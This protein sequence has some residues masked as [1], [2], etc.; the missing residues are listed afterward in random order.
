MKILFSLLFFVTF[1]TAFAQSYWEQNISPSYSQLMDTLKAWSQ[2]NPELELYQMGESDANVPIYICVVNGEKDSTKTFEK[3]R[4]K[5]TIL[6][7]NAIHPGEPDGINAMLIWIENWMKSEKKTNDLPV[8]AFI[9]AYNVDGMLNRNSSS[10]AN[11]N[12]PDEYGFRGTV[13]NYDLNRDFVKMDAQNS[14]VF[15]KIFHALDPDIFIDNHV[16]NGADYQY[17]LTYITSLKERMSPYL[18]ELTFSKMIP[19]MTKN[20]ARR[21]WELFPYVDLI[22]ETPEEGITAFNDLARYSNGYSSLFHT[23]S[24]TVETHMLKPFPQ[25]VKGTQAFMEETIKWVYLNQKQIEEARKKSFEWQENQAYFKFNYKRTKK[26]ES[27][28]F[29]GFKAS[30]PTSEVTG[31]PRL[32]Y[33][34]LQPY[35]KNIPYFK[36]HQASDSVLVPDY[37][38][39][40]S[41]EKEVITRLKANKINY[42][43]VQQDSTIN[44]TTTK[45]ESFKAINQPYEGHFKLEEIKITN[46]QESVTLHKGDLIIP[47]HQRGM[48]FLLQL[49]TPQAEDSYLSW[50]FFDSYLQQKEHFSSYIFVDEAEQILNSNPVLKKEFEEKKKND[51]QFRK[52]EWEQLNFIYMRSKF[53]EQSYRKLPVYQIFH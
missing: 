35:Q 42:K 3:A 26:A 47:T 32:K 30:Y 49:F 5:T 12:G 11:Q 9:P 22:G 13:R 14:F 27:I 23:I 25:R 53:H 29:K 51:E 18:Q 52:S 4:N 46:S 44:L 15:A 41:Q 1:Y 20:L 37:F 2:K 21:K 48:N 8:I 39:V 17:T 7:N 6:I 38:V 50:N 33:D 34:E 19:M 45:V 43:L 28:S 24:F 36:N 40:A 16:S 31:L 10:R